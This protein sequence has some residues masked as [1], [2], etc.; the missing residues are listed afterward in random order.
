[1]MFRPRVLS[2][3]TL[4]PKITVEIGSFT[5]VEDTVVLS[6]F[7]IVT[8]R[9]LK[10][11]RVVE[12]AEDPSNAQWWVLRQGKRDLAY[13]LTLR[14]QGTSHE[15]HVELPMQRQGLGW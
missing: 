14:N 10:Y 1:M 6:S 11:N 5:Y 3:S 13:S 9:I 15:S 2:K 4:N 8:T 12:Q 7:C